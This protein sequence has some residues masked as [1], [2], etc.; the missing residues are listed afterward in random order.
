M[1][2]TRFCSS[3]T[4]TSLIATPIP[5]GTCSPRL[6]TPDAPRPS[7]RTI[8]ISSR[9]RI[10]KNSCPDLGTPSTSMPAEFFLSRAPGCSVIPCDVI[11]KPL[12]AKDPSLLNTCPAG[13]ADPTPAFVPRASPLPFPGFFCGFFLSPFVPG[14]SKLKSI[15]LCGANPKSS[16]L[17]SSNGA[18]WYSSSSSSSFS[19]TNAGGFFDPFTFPTAPS[20][21]TTTGAGFAPIAGCCSPIPPPYVSLGPTPA[22]FGLL[23][24]GG[25][26]FRPSVFF[27]PAAASPAGASATASG[28]GSMGTGTGARS[29]G[30]KAAGGDSAGK[31][32]SS[33]WAAAR[34]VE[35]A[36]EAW[37]GRMPGGRWGE[38]GWKPERLRYSSCSAEEGPGGGRPS[39]WGVWAR[40]ETLLEES[41]RETV[42]NLA[43]MR[44]AKPPS[45]TDGDVSEVRPWAR[46]LTAELGLSES[47]PGWSESW[48][49]GLGDCGVLGVRRFLRNLPVPV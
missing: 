33:A 7:G 9:L 37:R 11:T 38:S 13:F 2:C 47:S 20:G 31:G 40:E 32:R 44:L 17:F 18:K 35:L 6:T 15:M 27:A 45:S 22:A 1:S 43:E 12:S 16:S 23:N 29:A 19:T 10:L 41:P 25:G 34:D 49:S 4:F 8:S 39:S 30:A 26:R 3:Y 24:S 21:A 36:E 46:R 14:L 5:D 42:R 28:S 48:R